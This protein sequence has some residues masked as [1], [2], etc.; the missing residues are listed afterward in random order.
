M[1]ALL[2]T[3]LTI[4]TSISEDPHARFKWP[5]AAEQLIAVPAQKMWDIISAPGNLELCHPFCDSN[6]VREWPGPRSQDEVHYLSGWVYVRRF[7]HWHDA[8]GY[9]LEIGREGGSTSFVSWR[10]TPVD[11]K[12]CV[13]RITVVP[14]ALQNWPTLIR[15]LPN[16]LRVRPLLRA[17]AAESVRPAPLVFSVPTTNVTQSAWPPSS[18]RP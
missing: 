8:V 5:V 17:G 7:K 9:D 2:R 3:R 11:E 14:Q 12:S 15:W 10:I 6:P 13:L 16:V 18:R 4:L 1:T